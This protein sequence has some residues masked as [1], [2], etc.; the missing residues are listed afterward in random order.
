MENLIIEGSDTLPNVELNVSGKIKIAG[1]AM[2]EDAARFFQ[3][4]HAW[5]TDFEGSDLNMDINLEYFNTSVS[6]QLFDFFTIINKKPNNCKIQLTWHYEEGDD[7]M[8]EAGEIYE[9]LFPR[10]NFRYNRYEEILEE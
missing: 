5:I 9:E 2:P 8:Y 7:E 10:F 4:L 6:K 1:R 3:P